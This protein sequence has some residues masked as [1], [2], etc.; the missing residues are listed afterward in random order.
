M[1]AGYQTWLADALIAADL[2]VKIEPGWKTRGHGPMGVPQGVLCHH[3]A[4]ASAAHG[5]APSI[6]IVRDGRPDLAGPLAQLVLGRD[7]TYH[8][9]A[10]GL[11]WHAG[12]GSYRGLIAGNLHLIGIEA[13]NQ[14]T[15]ADP[16]PAVQMDAYAR[17]AAALLAHIGAS[18][19]W[20]LG[21]K[22]WAP[23]RK[24]DPSFDMAKFR[25]S[26]A[27]HLPAQGKGA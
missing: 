27:A 22:E 21:H 23:G 13:E 8:V 24:I 16:W 9:I 17:G 12:P 26:V 5:P 6:P 19:E 3:T 10:A 15:P 4:G 18:V 14:G 7:G 1:T 20:C 11:C 2:D 25:Q